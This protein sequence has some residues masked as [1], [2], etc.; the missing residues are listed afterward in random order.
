MLTH[1]YR[2]DVWDSEDIEGQIFDAFYALNENEYIR[3]PLGRT[4]TFR[5][6]VVTKTLGCYFAPKD[7][8]VYDDCVDIRNDGLP[9]AC[10]L[11][12]GKNGHEH[13]TDK[14]RNYNP[15]LINYT[16]FPIKNLPPDVRK[17]KCDQY[18]KMIVWE[19]YED[20]VKEDLFDYCNIKY[21]GDPVH[22]V[23]MCAYA[24]IVKEEDRIVPFYDKRRY[25]FNSSIISK[26]YIRQIF[27]ATAS[28]YSDSKYLWN[29][30]CYYPLHDKFNTWIKF[31]VYPEHIKSLFYARDLPVTKAG[32][33][34]PIQH[35]VNAH[36]RRIKNGTEITQV[37]KHL[38]GI[39]KFEMFGYNFLISNPMKKDTI[40]FD[41]LIERDAWINQAIKTDPKCGGGRKRAS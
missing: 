41:E 12:I 2:K 15:D 17:M 13:M 21:K 23:T 1:L 26:G 35:W 39:N 37:K 9:G 34:R 10:S 40:P 27:S 6:C 7:R 18:Y 3:H 5:D 32:R 11:T 29:V 33:K 20:G 30:D 28:A 8:I 24:G 36:K 38:R 16:I 19:F 22:I 31:G 25:V 4:F 14:S